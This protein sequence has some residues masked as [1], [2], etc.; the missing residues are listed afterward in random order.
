MRIERIRKNQELYN[1]VNGKLYRVTSV[2]DTS[3]VASLM[4]ADTKEIV[5]GDGAESIAVNEA[6][7]ICFRIVCDPDPEDIPVGYTVSDGV[8]LKNQVPVTEQGEI[9]VLEILTSLPGYLV[10]TAKSKTETDVDLLIYEPS[11]DRF[12]YL[13]RSVPEV[14]VL[15]EIDDKVLLYF[16]SVVTKTEKNEKDEDVEYEV[17]ENSGVI[18]V[19]N[20]Q[21][22]ALAIDIPCC[23]DA[24]S[25]IDEDIF[26]YYTKQSNDGRLVDTT[27]GY[28]VIDML[29]MEYTRCVVTGE[30]TEITRC[31]LYGYYVFKSDKQIICDTSDGLYITSDEIAKLK[32][33]DN[34][35]D[36]TRDG[37][38]TL[39]T[40][41]NDKLEV[42]TLSR[43]STRDRGYIVKV[44]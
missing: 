33:Y 7:S 43:Q 24:Y 38:T 16:S 14:S 23:K 25:R 31:M 28:M 15:E 30:P 32:G 11:R 3:G 35:V 5:L 34:L 41:A 13:Y 12:K 18:L 40:F 20:K 27:P 37:Y 39:V 6:N 44:S 10:L 17:L 4:D 1:K 9:K 8:L 29:D 21:A 22:Y 2:T 19:A 42:K 36:I 26:L